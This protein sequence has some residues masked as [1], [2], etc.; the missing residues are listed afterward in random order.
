M[1]FGKQIG[2]LPLGAWVAVVAGGLGI[3]LWS[4]QKSAEPP[5]VVE[6]TSGTP[7]VGEGGTGSW[8]DIAKPPTDNTAPV[9]YASNE[10]WG[11]AA[12]NWLIAQGYAPGLASAAITKALAGG[13]DIDG[14]KM[15]IQE[16]SLWTLAL[17][18]LGS[19][20]QPVNVAP[21]SSVPGPVTPPGNPPPTRP[22]SPKPGKPVP[23]VVTPPT[24]PQGQ[25]RY[26]EWRISVKYPT[27]SHLVAASNK[28]HGTNYTWEYVWA[29]NLK[30][31]SPATVAL[32]KVRG[33][34]ATFM[35]SMFEIPY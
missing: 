2:P 14:N 18:Q 26:E 31:R 27:L 13:T 1:D 9:G 10:S 20:P 23:P 16:W 34:H 24:Q 4:R 21:P 6:D 33:P 35:N 15:S 7:G 30:W 8:V 19:P 22:P 11:Q 25:G 3:A 12:V 17:K 5:V 28:K 29:Y 32:L